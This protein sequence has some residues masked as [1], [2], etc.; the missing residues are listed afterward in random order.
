MK[1]A[2]RKVISTVILAARKEIST[3]IR[4]LVVKYKNENK[5]FGE[6]AKLLNLSKST[7]QTIF[8]NYKNNG[9]VENKIRSGRQKKSKGR[10]FYYKRSGKNP[11]VNATKLA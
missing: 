10:K 1:M 9:T 11:K 7:V 5:S 8:N 2:P 3:D 6:I 4:N